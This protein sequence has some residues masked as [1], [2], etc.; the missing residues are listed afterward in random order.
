M[1][2]RRRASACGRRHRHLRS[3]RIGQRRR[4]RTVAV[5]DGRGGSA[6]Q[7]LR[8]WIGTGSAATAGLVA[9]T[10]MALAALQRRRQFLEADRAVAVLVE[11]AEHAVGLRQI[12]AAGAERLFEFRLADLAVAV[13]VDLREQ[14]LQRG[15]AALGRRASTP[16]D[17]W[18]CA[19][20]SALMVCGDIDDQPPPPEPAPAPT[21]AEPFEDD[22]SN[23]LCGVLADAGRLSQTISTKSAP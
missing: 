17:D 20:S 5:G 12:G 9:I 15:R 7:G 6:L 10:V 16:A 19:S 13:A 18:L 11:L 8:E 4:H 23:G 2:R 3:V 21:E 22:S 1:S 14:I